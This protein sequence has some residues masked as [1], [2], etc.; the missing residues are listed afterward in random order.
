LFPSTSAIPVRNVCV[1]S[2]RVHRFV[3]N[4]FTLHYRS[5]PD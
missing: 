3:F 5:S 2:T 4:H 1:S